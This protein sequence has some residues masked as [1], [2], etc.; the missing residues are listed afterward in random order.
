[1]SIAADSDVHVD[2]ADYILGT[3]VAEYSTFPPH[4]WAAVPTTEPHSNNGAESF[5]MHY[6]AMYYKAH[7]NIHLVITNLLETVGDRYENCV[8]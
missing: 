5:H 6:N 1:M 2:F 4:M 7:P 8:N 3:N